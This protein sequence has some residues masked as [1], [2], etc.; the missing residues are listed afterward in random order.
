MARGIKTGGRKRG[1]RN[2]K[3][4]IRERA[5]AASGELPVDYMLRVMRDK[6]VKT[7]RRDDMARAAAPYLHARLATAEPRRTDG[8]YVPLLERLEEYTREAAI[9]ARGGKVV[10]LKSRKKSPDA[11]KSLGS[12]WARPR[13]T[14]ST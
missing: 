11:G 8:A 14:L 3:T 1:S 13:A 2:K 6:R 5:I 10:P 4:I 9:E 7:A 12:T